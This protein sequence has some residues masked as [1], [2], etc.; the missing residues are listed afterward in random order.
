MEDLVDLLKE[1]APGVLWLVFCVVIVFT[2]VV[3][4]ALSYHWHEYATDAQKSRFMFRGYL[5]VAGILALV[6]IMALLSY[7]N[8][9]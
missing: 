3:A 8:G 4:A 2:A 6:M 7:Q 5:I 9:I 1:F